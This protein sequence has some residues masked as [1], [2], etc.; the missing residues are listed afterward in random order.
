[1]A[2]HYSGVHRKTKSS[3]VGILAVSFLLNF[4]VIVAL[5]YTYRSCSRQTISAD[6]VFHGGHPSDTMRGT[7]FCSK[8][9]VY[10]MCNPS[11]AI[12]VVIF[13][14][15]DHLLLVRRKDTNQLAVMGGF[16]EVG[17]SVADA[18]K[19]E[20]KEETGLIL[21]KPPILFGVYS[22][23]R[24]DNRRHTASAVFAIHLDGTEVP[25]AA[26]DVKAVERVPVT[27]IDA[28]DNFFSD[29]KTII[30]DYLKLLDGKRSASDF[31][32]SQGDYSPDIKRS[33]CLPAD[34]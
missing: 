31:V 6:L 22:D 19:R 20:L 23:P 14:G 25:K 33:I 28:M 2:V 12:D 16:V 10:C 30:S 15:K 27:E 32:S 13:S 26:D 8:E 1:M 3:S 4:L 17:E 5:V 18:V 24:R 21:Q 29:H 34:V 11:L 9:D 7:C